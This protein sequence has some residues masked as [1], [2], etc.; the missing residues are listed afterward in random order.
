MMAANSRYFNQIDAHDLVLYNNCSLDETKGRIY[1]EVMSQK[2]IKTGIKGLDTIFLGGMLPNRSYLLLGSAGTGKTIL[3]LQWLLA[4]QRSGEKSLYISLAE[5]REDI[6]NDVKSFGW[7]LKE[8]DMVD[9]IPAEERQKDSIEEYHIFTPDEVEE[10]EVWNMIYQTVAEKKPDRLVIDSA[11]QLRFLSTDTYQFRKRILAL[12][13]YL[14]MHN[15]TSMLLF[16]PAEMIHDTSVALAVDGILHL[17]METL[18][19][20]LVASRYMEINKLRGSDFLSGYHPFR[21][22]KSGLHVYPHTIETTD[23]KES[24]TREYDKLISSGNL[25]LDEMLGG[26]I[27]SGTTTI[28]SGPTGTGKSVLALQFLIQQARQGKQGLAILFEESVNS[29]IYRCRALGMPIDDLLQKNMLRFLHIN[30]LQ[31]YPDELLT[32]VRH[33]IKKDG[34]KFVM[35]DGLRGYSIAMEEFGQGR[36]IQH[37][38]NLIT[39]LN[40]KKVTTFL[41]NEVEVIRGSLRI[42][43]H[44]LSHLGDNIILLRFAERD[45]KVFKIIGC[46]KKRLGDF[47]SE[48][49]EFFITSNGLVI[50]EKLQHL[51]GILSGLERYNIKKSLAFSHDTK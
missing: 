38:H 24:R 19:S 18:P 37:L 29:V 6:E 47:Q 28:I 3:S 43:E 26:G 25:R 49:R 23:N 39:H 11:S 14:N 30:S 50:S 45:G 33:C 16:E 27:E 17:R 40:R 36:I 20:R 5:R 46:L 42:T 9:F 21:I 15:V 12:T 22:L 8:I 32:K 34:Y 7:N 4:G 13:K 10:T 44:G 51:E 48:S 41:V 1:M 2:K 35:I 31:I